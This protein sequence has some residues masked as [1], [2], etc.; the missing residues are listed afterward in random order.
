VLEDDIVLVAAGDDPHGIAERVQLGLS[1]DSPVTCAVS[2]AGDLAGLPDAHRSAARSVRLLLSLGRVGALG[3]DTTLAPYALLFGEHSREDLDRFLDATIGPLL[4]WD[5]S[6]SADLARTLLT[7]L[8]CGQST[9]AAS[10]ALH[11]HPNTLRQRLE[12]VAAVLSAW[13]DPTR[14]LE[15]HMALRL[16]AIRTGHASPPERGDAP[17]GLVRG[18]SQKPR[19]MN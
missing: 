12:R 3:T 11:I 19:L 18:G 8:D 14:V 10:Q 1:T 4:Q 5:Q 7:Y 15:I 13:R 9:A 6:R 16:E 2:T 17:V